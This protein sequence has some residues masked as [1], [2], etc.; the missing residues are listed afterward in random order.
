MV[1]TMQIQEG[2][3]LADSNFEPDRVCDEKLFD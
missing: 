3:R 2:D 1:G